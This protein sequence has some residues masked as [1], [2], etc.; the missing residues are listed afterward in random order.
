MPGPVWTD[1]GKRKS[2]FFPPEFETRTVQG[3]ASRY[4]DCSGP[5]RVAVY[6]LNICQELSQS[7]L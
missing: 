1:V 7:L 4:T 2:L 5:N 3:V 6:E